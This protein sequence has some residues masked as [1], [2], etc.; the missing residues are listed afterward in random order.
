MSR[1]PKLSRRV[2]WAV[3][4]GALVVTGGL[5][6]AAL[7]PSAQAAPVLPARTAAQLIADV[8][9]QPHPLAFSGTVTE[10]ASLGLPQ[11]PTTQSA[12][13]PLSLLTGSH[14][15]QVWFANPH[16]YRLALPGSMSETD[17]YRD[18]SVAWLWQS[19]PDT[20]TKFVSAN[21]DT[22]LRAPAEMSLTP[23]QAASDVLA[24]VGPTT[25][26]S[27]DSSAYVAGQAAYE[28][29]LAPKDARSLIG[30]VRIAVDAANSTPLRVEVYAKNATSPAISIGFTSITFAAPSAGDLTF[31]PPSGAKVTTVN[32]TKD[33]TGAPGSGGGDVGVAGSDWLTVLKLPASALT[34]DSGTGETQA[35]IQALLGSATTVHG[36]WGSGQLIRTSLVSVLITSGTMYVGAVDPSVLYAAAA[37]H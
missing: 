28:L 27:V 33:S 8:A 9:A 37:Q 31:T 17:V 24:A 19:V 23:Q 4:G 30:Q 20:V 15:V 3:P 14:T 34:G 35:A 29:V 25:T 13:S 36:T 22:N 11:L 5:M 32:L 10:T 6:A 2:R 12:T 26:V 1:I 16:Q 18:G 21:A 7:M